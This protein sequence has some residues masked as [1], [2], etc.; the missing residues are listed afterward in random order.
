MAIDNK[1]KEELNKDTNIK[2]GFKVI[3]N[4]YKTNK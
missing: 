4:K 3:L 1:Y 2:E